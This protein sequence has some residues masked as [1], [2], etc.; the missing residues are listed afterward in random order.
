MESNT[1]P[2]LLRAVMDSTD[3]EAVVGSASY[4]LCCLASLT[5]YLT[6]AC[7][8]ARFSGDDA[9]ASRIERSIDHIDTRRSEGL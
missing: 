8:F 2:E 5:E 9:A 6:G 3:V 4:R 1:P 7:Q